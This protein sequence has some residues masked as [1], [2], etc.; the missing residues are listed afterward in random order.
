VV[1]E[2]NLD[3][4]DTCVG[5]PDP[6]LDLSKEIL[7]TEY[8]GLNKYRVTYLVK[9][10]NSGD[11]P[12]L[13]GIDDITG[14]GAGITLDGTPVV[15]Y[16]AINDLFA[17]PVTA[18]AWTQIALNETVAGQKGESWQIVAEIDL[19]PSNNDYEA[20]HE[21]V[22]NEG[23]WVSGKGF[24]NRVELGDYQEDN[25]LNNKICSNPD[26]PLINLSKQAAPAVYVGGGQFDVTYTFT[27][28]YD[29]I[30]HLKPSPALTPIAIQVPT[31]YVAGIENDQDGTIE[32]PLIGDFT[33]IGGAALV[34]DET[35]AAGGTESWT[36]TIRF[37][38][39]GSLA[40]AENANCVDDANE[41]GNTGFNNLILGSATDIDLVDNE[42]CVDLV[43]GRIEIA[44]QLSPPLGD[45][46]DFINATPSALGGQ[47]GHMGEIGKDV[48]PGTY[49]TTLPRSA[50]EF[51]SWIWLVQDFTCDDGDS[52][53]DLANL[54]ELMATFKVNPSETVRCTL[55]L[56]LPND[57]SVPVNNPWALVLMTLMM[58]ATGWYFRPAPLRKS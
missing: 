57:M 39:D 33:T 20:N 50:L 34:S 35:L 44:L 22:S 32:N 52:L 9:V 36:I 5:L 11:G 1:D 15:T 56:M 17:S 3:D 2:T 58:L 19:D 30:D 12:G 37:Q 51:T 8:I 45:L 4:N 26:D 23:G 16:V 24:F 28:A 6:D 27:E 25:I 48:W 21:C 53:I 41:N 49:V 47:I 46:F 14:F 38:L 7:L 13:Y 43:G 31:A 54:V 18:P 10:Q 42:A 29:L 55:L 40:T